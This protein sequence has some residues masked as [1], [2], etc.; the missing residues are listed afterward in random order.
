MVLLC[1]EASK[2]RRQTGQSGFGDSQNVDCFLV[3][4]SKDFLYARTAKPSGAQLWRYDGRA[5]KKVN[6]GISIN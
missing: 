3:S 5:W 4:A 1:Y 2:A 6:T